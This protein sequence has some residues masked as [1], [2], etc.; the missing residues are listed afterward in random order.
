MLSNEPDPPRSGR[1]YTTLNSTYNL[2]LYNLQCN[3]A[4][5]VDLVVW[6]LSLSGLLSGP[7][8]SMRPARA[9]LLSSPIPGFPTPRS[10]APNL[11]RLPSLEAGAGHSSVR[12]PP[13]VV[14]G[15]RPAANTPELLGYRGQ[16]GAR[17]AGAA[18]AG[19]ARAGVAAHV[20]RPEARLQPLVGSPRY[21]S[22]PARHFAAAGVSASLGCTEEPPNA[23]ALRDHEIEKRERQW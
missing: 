19:C 18:S 23:A 10:L 8:G 13:A 16:G 3:S 5:A 21:V 7:F 14:L 2:V 20:P 15:V 11:G 9:D 6:T 12:W 4:Q 22:F 1:A 17:G